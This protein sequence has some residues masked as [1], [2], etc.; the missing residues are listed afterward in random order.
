MGFLFARTRSLFRPGINFVAVSRTRACGGVF[1][2]AVGLFFGRCVDRRA[3]ARVRRFVRHG[4]RV[5]KARIRVIRLCGGYFFVSA[6]GNILICIGRIARVF[7][8]VAENIF[9]SVLARRTENILKIVVGKGFISLLVVHFDTS[10]E[11]VPFILHENGN[12]YN[13]FL[14]IS[15]EI[16]AQVC[17]NSKLYS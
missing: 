12:L 7:A 3:I 4:R 2:I 15:V 16:P 1:V 10:A 8:A 6:A 17:Y 14:K 11:I 13:D 9:K 5:K